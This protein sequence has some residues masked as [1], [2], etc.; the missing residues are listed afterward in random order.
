MPRWIELEGC[1]NVRDLGGYPTIGGRQVRYGRLYRSGS[2]SAMSP[3]AVSVARA[4]LGL[5]TVIDLRHPDEIARAGRAPLVDH[6]CV[7]ENPRRARGGVP[8]VEL[9][10]NHV[11]RSEPRGTHRVPVVLVWGERVTCVMRSRGDEDETAIRARPAVARPRGG[12]R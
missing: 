12:R 5:R 3:A 10:R 4:A 7:G 9:D 11:T 1:R 8:R 6:D 2:L